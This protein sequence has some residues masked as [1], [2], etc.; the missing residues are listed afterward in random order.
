MSAETPDFFHGSFTL[1]RRWK[2]TPTRVFAAWADMDFKAL[3]FP[4]IAEG[5]TLIRRELD[6][7]RGGAEILEGRFNVSGL[8]TLYE[9]RFHLIE[10]DRRLVYSYD[11][12]HNE[13]FHSVTLSSLNIVPEGERTRVSYTEQIAFLDGQDGTASRRHGTE[14]QW[15]ALETALLSKRVM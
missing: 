9:A 15:A 7:C 1:T 10:P 2:T 6:F 11:L 13:T 3:W 8:R 12:F 4:N 14:I 5:W